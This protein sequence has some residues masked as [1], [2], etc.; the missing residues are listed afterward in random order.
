MQALVS[1]P[2]L[3]EFCLAPAGSLQLKKGPIGSAL[4]ELV[5][6][7]YGAQIFG[8]AHS[9]LQRIYASQARKLIEETP[10]EGSQLLGVLLL[11]V[12]M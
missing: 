5:K 12:W 6:T 1:V 10:E 4:Q 8:H 9:S 2:Q 7:V 11:P 3:R